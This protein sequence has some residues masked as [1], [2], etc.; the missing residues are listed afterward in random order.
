MTC[1]GFFDFRIKR[2]IIGL[3]TYHHFYHH[4]THVSSF[5]EWIDST[6][7][8][9]IHPSHQPLQQRETCVLASDNSTRKESCSTVHNLKII[10]STLKMEP[11]KEKHA[12]AA[13]KGRGSGKSQTLDTLIEH[14]KTKNEALLIP[15]RFGPT[16]YYFTDGLKQ[17]VAVD[18]LLALMGSIVAVVFNHDAKHVFFHIQCYMP[19]FPWEHFNSLEGNTAYITLLRQFLTHIMNNCSLNGKEKMILF[20]DGIDDYCGRKELRPMCLNDYRLFVDVIFD[21]FVRNPIFVNKDGCDIVIPTALVIAGRKPI[22]S[23]IKTIPLKLETSGLNEMSSSLFS[24]LPTK[25]A[26]RNCSSLKLLK[27]LCI[28]IPGLSVCLSTFAT[29]QFRYLEKYKFSKRM[30][31]EWI[32]ELQLKMFHGF[33]HRIDFHDYCNDVHNLIFQDK[34]KITDSNRIV[35]EELVGSSIR[36]SQLFNGDNTVLKPEG[37]LLALGAASL[38]EDWVLNW[39]DVRN[40]FSNPIMQAMSVVAS[41]SSPS[42]KKQFMKFIAGWLLTRIS[43][44]FLRGLDSGLPLYRLLGLSSKHKLKGFDKT[45]KLAWAFSNCG[46]RQIF[47]PKELF[48]LENI[49]EKPVESAQQLWS[50]CSKYRV[51]QSQGL[52]IYLLDPKNQIFDFFGL[53]FDENTLE[54]FILFFVFENRNISYLECIRKF[55]ET[56]NAQADMNKS[57]PLWKAVK[58]GNFRI[59]TSVDE[60]SNA[61]LFPKNTIF[62][63]EFEVQKFFGISYP[64]YK[65]ACQ[66]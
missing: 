14:L 44:V 30:L 24:S 31:Q 33:S 29:G 50:Y 64:F 23:D 19:K 5:S 15:V 46:R 25:C 53:F 41:A 12:I 38:D 9:F 6:F 54:P 55:Q 57:H 42:F 58:I 66:I 45:I 32:R 11:S 8:R 1:A 39:N 62:L 59:I 48:H 49:F 65:A 63:K 3:E 21:S 61:N 35:I 36:T 34:V 18:A 60:D 2:T 22:L 52:H 26:Q 27:A 43:V 10:R 56:V 40:T 4:P 51:A 47:H 16:K 7:Q 17:S 20:I 13:F 37:S 28:D